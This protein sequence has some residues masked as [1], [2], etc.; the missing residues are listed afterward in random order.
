MAD[1]KHI[2]VYDTTLRDGCQSEDVSLT[3]EDKVTIAERL[4]E[5]GI[6]YVEGGW[7][8]SNDRDAAFFKEI[9]K[10]KLRHAKIAAFGSTRRAG[11]KAAADRNLQLLL[12]AETP[13]A[14]VVGKTWDLHVREALRISNQENLEILNDTIAFLKKNFDQALFDAEHFFDGY[15]AN[16]EFALAC[17]RA[18]DDAGVTLIALCDTNGGRLPHEIEAAVTAARAAVNCPIGIHCH[19][20]SEVA[21]ANTLA[22]VHAGAVQV[23][24]TING[25]G[26][27]CGNANLI[28]IIANL[29]LKL[30]Y[31][32]VPPAK[33]KTLRE[34]SR[35]VYE[36]ANITPFARQ[37]YVGRSAFA[38]KG[39]LHVSGIQRNTKTYEHLDPEL[40]GNDRRVLL[41]ELSGRANIVYKAKEFG[42]QIDPSNEKI[43]VLLEELKRL[44]AQGYTYDGA[45]ASFELLMLRTLGM[46]REHFNFV[47]FRV[48]DDKWHEEQAPF[49][50]A[51]IVLEGPDGARTRN[52][53]IGNGPVNAMDSALRAALVPYYPNLE[54]MQLVDYKVRVL[55]NGV[56]TEARVRVLIESTD[57]K[58]RWGT[59]GLSSNVVEASWQALV[60]SIEYKL[61]KDN[62]KPR[63]RPAAPKLNGAHPRS[64]A[65]AI[66][67]VSAAKV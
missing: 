5:L 26:E 47:S 37:P 22:G 9:K 38:H 32:C 42:L 50:E 2:Q 25:F 27:R 19:N 44:E 49:S 24:G 46:T 43:G 64:K 30:G 48:F 1:A 54:K 45:D 66:N 55:D 17:L 23:Q 58:R 6:D 16:P 61:H 62:V 33:V 31:H 21:V 51:V 34:V 11:I 59:V 12:R 10:S 53:A 40:V 18:V 60:D 29:Q 14:T 28:S 36:L 41:S 35:L 13:V 15:F 67:Q 7:P 52:S 63:S 56:G 20:D 39:G 65:A 3:V 57:G 4:D 8:G